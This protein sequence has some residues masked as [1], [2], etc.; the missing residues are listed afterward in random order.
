[1]IASALP[2]GPEPGSRPE[3]RVQVFRPRREPFYVPQADEVAIFTA[4][5]TGRTPVLLMGPTGTGKTRFVEHMAWRLGTPAGGVHG[6]GEAQGHRARPLVTVACH[7]DLTAGDLVG[8]H[9]LDATGTRWMDGPLTHAMRAG[10]ICY[11]DELVEARADTT[12][13][14]HPAA[15]HRRSLSIDKRGELLRAQEGFFLVA[16]YNP[17]YQAGSKTL[18]RSTRQRFVCIDLQYPSVARE[19]DIVAHESGVPLA[20]AQRLAELSAR[21]R[22]LRDHDMAD[23][24]ST[25][26]LVAAG[27]LIVAGITPRRAC[28]VAVV[29]GVSDDPLVQA[30]VDEVVTAFFP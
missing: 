7:E 6:D 19:A 9:L 21:L 23:A 1:M 20:L 26:A 8:R 3:D 15:D 14:I 27:R 28:Q 30:G 17:G 10:A 13:V 29:M 16:S 2:V 22:G 25:R 12:V 11:L 5:Y 24:V 18:K 4:A